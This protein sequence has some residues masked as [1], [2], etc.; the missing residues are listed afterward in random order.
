[1]I[2]EIFTSNGTGI[3]RLGYDANAMVDA[4]SDAF[5]DDDINPIQYVASSENGNSLIDLT[6]LYSDRNGNSASAGFYSD[7]DVVRQYEWDA[8]G[9]YFTDL[10]VACGAASTHVK[11]VRTGDTQFIYGDNVT[12]TDVRYYYIDGNSLS[13]SSGIWTDELRLIPAPDDTYFD[14]GWNPS[15][16]LTTNNGTLYAIGHNNTVVSYAYGTA[17]NV[18]T[19]DQ[20]NNGY[21]K[22]WDMHANNLEDTDP[23]HYVYRIG[24]T[25][26][27]VL[28]IDDITVN[29]V[30]V[31][32]VHL[33]VDIDGCDNINC[34]IVAYKISH[35]QTLSF[36]GGGSGSAVGK[37][38]IS[39]LSNGV[40]TSNYS[41]FD[42]LG[43]IYLN[44]GVA[45]VGTTD[46]LNN[47]ACNDFVPFSNTMN[48]RYL[49]DINGIGVF[50]LQDAVYIY[51][52]FWKT[53]LLSTSAWLGDGTYW[54]YWDASNDSFHDFTD[55]GE[56]TVW[57]A[58]AD[59][60]PNQYGIMMSYHAAE[61]TSEYYFDLCAMYD[62]DFTSLN[63]HYL[64][65]DENGIAAG[66]Y[67]EFWGGSL[68][69]DVGYYRYVASPTDR[70]LRF[71]N[72]TSF[73][74]D[75]GAFDCHMVSHTPLTYSH[76]MDADP[77]TLCSSTQMANFNLSSPTD[78]PASAILHKTQ[79]QLEYFE[80]DVILKHSSSPNIRKWNADSNTFTE[81]ESCVQLTAINVQISRY[82]QICSKDTVVR[83]ISGSTITEGS[84]LYMDEYGC[85]ESTPEMYIRTVSDGVLYQLLAD[86]TFGSF[87]DLTDCANLTLM[88]GT[89]FT[90]DLFSLCGNDTNEG[91]IDVYSPNGNATILYEIDEETPIMYAD[92]YGE[93]LAD[94]GYYIV[95]NDYYYW[96]GF[97]FSEDIITCPDRFQLTLNIDSDI[98]YICTTVNTID[99]WIDSSETFATVTEFFTSQYGPNVLDTMV[100][101]MS[102]GT[103]LNSISAVLLDPVSNEY[104]RWNSESGST[105]NAV[106]SCNTHPIYVGIM[107]HSNTQ[108]NDANLACEALYSNAN[109]GG[110]FD[111]YDIY[112]DNA[113]NPTTLAL[114][115]IGTPVPDGTY[116]DGLIVIMSS[117]GGSNIF[118]SQS[119]CFNLVPI[120][121]N[122]NSDTAITDPVLCGSLDGSIES[123]YYIHP[124]TSG[125]LSNATAIFDDIYSI[126]ISATGIY[127]DV[128]LE[129]YV[130]FTNIDGT[131]ANTSISSFNNCSTHEQLEIR[132]G[133]NDITVDPSSSC[134]EGIGIS[135]VYRYFDDTFLLAS[136]IYL[137]IYGNDKAPSGSYSVDNNYRV[138][139]S[140][141]ETLSVAVACTGVYSVDL[142]HQTDGTTDCDTFNTNSSEFFMNAQL[143]ENATLF[144]TNAIGSIPASDGNYNNGTGFI[145]YT[146]NEISIPYTICGIL[147]PIEL[148][149]STDINEICLL[150]EEET[151]TYYI[152]E[153]PLYF[154]HTTMIYSTVYGSPVNDNTGIPASG[155]YRAP[156]PSITNAVLYL[157][158]VVD[159]GISLPVPSSLPMGVSSTHTCIPMT[160]IELGYNIT[161]TDTSVC[162][163]DTGY[164]TG[165]FWLS[166]TTLGD[167]DVTLYTADDKSGIAPDGWYMNPLTTT[168]RLVLGGVWLSGVEEETCTL[169]SEVS[170]R[171]SADDVNVAQLTDAHDLV[172]YATCHSTSTIVSEPFFVDGDSFIGCDYLYTTEEANVFADSGIYTDGTSWRIWDVTGVFLSYN[173]TNT[174]GKLAYVCSEVYTPLLLI[175][176]TDLLSICEATT[177]TLYFVDHADY[178]DENTN[179]IVRISSRIYPITQGIIGNYGLVVHH[180][181]IEESMYFKDS[182]DGTVHYWDTTAPF[183]SNLDPD[184]FI[185]Q[186]P[187]CTVM[188][189]IN[190]KIDVTSSQTYVS[191]LCDIVYSSAETIIL[192]GNAATLEDSTEIYNYTTGLG[193]E[194]GYDTSIVPLT[195]ENT[196]MHM[197]DVTN[198]SSTVRTWNG[199]SF[200]ETDHPCVEHT[201][202][203]LLSSNGIEEPICTMADADMT[204]FFINSDSLSTATEIYY[205][206]YGENIVATSQSFMQRYEHGMALN[207]SGQDVYSNKR[208][209]WTYN[210]VDSIGV[211]TDEADCIVYTT[212]I[213]FKKYENFNDICTDATSAGNFSYYIE[214]DND[215]TFMT[216]DLIRTSHY[217][218]IYTGPSIYVYDFQGNNIRYYN[219][220]PVEVDSTEIV[221]FNNDMLSNIPGEALYFKCITFPYEYTVAYN[222]DNNLDVCSFNQ[223]KEHTMLS[224]VQ[225]SSYGSSVTLYGN[226]STFA[227]S[228]SLSTHVYDWVSP[229][230]GYYSDGVNTL[231]HFTDTENASFLLSNCSMQAYDLFIDVNGVLSPGVTSSMV[232]FYHT[233]YSNA[234]SNT[235]AHACMSNDTGTYLDSTAQVYLHVID[236]EDATDNRS[237]LFT[238]DS[239]A[240]VLAPDGSYSFKAVDA[241]AVSAVFNV[242]DA[243]PTN[244]IYPYN[245]L[246]ENYALSSN[247]VNYSSVSE[248]IVCNAPDD[249]P[250]TAVFGNYTNI[251]TGAFI[252][253]TGTNASYFLY[254]SKWG[255]VMDNDIVPTG[256]YNHAQYTLYSDEFGVATLTPTTCEDAINI[257]TIEY[258]DGSG[259]QMA[260]AASGDA[261]FCDSV[262]EDFTVLP[263]VYS[264]D[265][266][267]TSTMIMY[268]YL[269]HPQNG[270]TNLYTDVHLISR[271]KNPVVVQNALYRTDFCTFLYDKFGMAGKVM[272]NKAPLLFTSTVAD[273]DIGDFSYTLNETGTADIEYLLPHNYTSDNADSITYGI[274][275]SNR[276]AQEHVDG[277]DF[278]T[279]YIQPVFGRYHDGDGFRAYGSSGFYGDFIQTGALSLIYSSTYSVI[280]DDAAGT[281]YLLN[282][283]VG[284]NSGVTFAT[285][286]HIYKLNAGA[287]E[288]VKETTPGFYNSG[289]QVRYLNAGG[290][291]SAYTIG[292]IGS[293]FNS[294]VDKEDLCAEYLNTK[295]EYIFNSRA[296]NSSDAMYMYTILDETLTPAP[297]GWYVEAEGL[298]VVRQ[299]I[300]PGI[301]A[302]AVGS[303]DYILSTAISTKY[304]AILSH[305]LEND[306]NT[307]PSSV[308][309]DNALPFH[310]AHTLYSDIISTPAPTGY[311][312]D[313]TSYRY[314][315]GNVLQQQILLGR[316]L[317]YLS[318]TTSPTTSCLYTNPNAYFINYAAGVIPDVSSE[319]LI[320]IGVLYTNSMGK[321]TASFV[322]WYVDSQGTGSGVS[323]G[324]VIGLA[325][326][327]CNISR[328]SG[329]PA[330]NPSGNMIA[331]DGADFATATNATSTTLHKIPPGIYNNG[332]ISRYFDGK[333]LGPVRPYVIGNPILLATSRITGS[334]ACREF[335]K[336]RRT[337]YIKNATLSTSN[338]IFLDIDMTIPAP[339]GYYTNVV[340]GI[341]KWSPF[342][343]PGG[344]LY[345]GPPCY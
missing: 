266:F 56:L 44:E 220:D 141:N 46:V 10:L 90:K 252:Y 237:M 193:G 123:T 102:D 228:T 151:Q 40:L 333:K 77:C 238:L 142:Y 30:G 45:G 326:A 37:G 114:D 57:D 73:D 328:S 329:V 197:I 64:S 92:T 145:Q 26:G 334:H 344:T 290:T 51:E 264:H 185:I 80:T 34:N 178:S 22:A 38:D 260:D 222:L 293:M 121:L 27:V 136:G 158:G 236:D 122:Y 261:T 301:L 69:T 24:G 218:T 124:V 97:E 284:S 15:K 134:G 157:V 128:D 31:A 188:T 126:Q 144:Y 81:L 20:I 119:V 288:W 161:G 48:I 263:D 109:Y 76:D 278:S 268:P 125:L 310:K 35:V 127:S 67:S 130:E 85:V 98:S 235:S 212:S 296:T 167:A 332:T 140:A 152:T 23:S 189:Y 96:D 170:L 320:D 205:D 192:Y 32:Y 139:D 107:G 36:A 233:S 245:V 207:S 16:F 50:S 211:F 242:V 115:T 191:G 65:Y 7:G 61:S 11:L 287:T 227:T 58:C 103:S 337:Y 9:G 116:S 104:L 6:R 214:S 172:I 247:D 72:G 111:T 243:H 155:Y 250:K 43:A 254:N 4:C 258:L 336:E 342:D 239:Y 153:E 60:F 21:Y 216:M 304:A 74:T 187:E 101:L 317:I 138:W 274:Y 120:E 285:A 283:E 267:Q 25:A 305:D 201:S 279:S 13:E 289:S 315:D 335:E 94:P 182:A 269:N 82:L 160:S 133:F 175:K 248:L 321:A 146:S 206:A 203:M 41:N 17:A 338:A 253:W 199:V 1:M 226:G 280:C 306:V 246:C 198:P 118:V 209:Y 83:Y 300:E 345:P 14:F 270:D 87:T 208:R 174:Y 33:D 262:I 217:G 186:N 95:S 219:M 129:S 224:D 29:G 176:T 282:A 59:L 143:F 286:K 177:E 244:L 54:K 135:Q 340:D 323:L 319:I 313:D 8:D 71:W 68:R 229:T 309:T 297:V 314:W 148:V 275:N 150:S 308:F 70:T 168:K 28:T 341:Y 79:Y 327:V 89:R 173:N 112:S 316:F 259:Q 19:L 171:F 93:Y 99:V 325:T 100:D 294:H 257:G 88:I 231:N 181:Y 47:V 39:T 202:I 331:Y 52:D 277:N 292:C 210:N 18:F 241:G 156:D 86:G 213:G 105:D 2:I 137:D 113:I 62:T 53:T 108:N 169:I 272:C 330:V 291:F 230:N 265:Y 190:V 273:T 281:Q 251:T 240:N 215:T 154:S 117:D 234:A 164:A 63:W 66:L 223:I 271:L 149:Y 221:G 339:E 204:E 55:G 295:T 42:V 195:D 322:N 132:V 84:R 196:W 184:T 106:E 307:T 302:K 343:S 324:G 78:F 110:T 147:N 183:S 303:C 232:N 180:E 200:E 249:T 312:R 165:T 166:G 194:Y 256:Y 318:D 299:I 163:G 311:Y 159:A 91:T 179:D 49:T 12:S 162:P 3:I 5:V 276:L 75:F 225:I 298:G 131:N 255:H